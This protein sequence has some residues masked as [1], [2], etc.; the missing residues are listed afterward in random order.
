MFFIYS[1]TLFLLAAGTAWPA[2]PATNALNP[3]LYPDRPRF[4]VFNTNEFRKVVPEGRDIKVLAN[5]INRFTTGLAWNPR[6]KFL[7]ISEV[8]TN[9]LF[10]YVP[11]AGLSIFRHPSNF[12]SGNAY[13]SLG[14]LL[15]CENANGRIVVLQEDGSLEP[16]VSQFEGKSLNSPNDI[17]LKSDGTVWFSDPD[18]GLSQTRT[19]QQGGNFI[20]SYDPQSKICRRR[21]GPFEKPTGLCFSPNEKWLY[22]CNY[23][24]TNLFERID[25]FQMLADG[26]LKAG[27]AFIQVK[28]PS[29]GAVRCDQQGRI[30][31]CAA[32]GVHIYGADGKPIGQISTSLSPA[33]LC[34]GGEGN[35]T[36]FVAARR[37]LYALETLVVGDHAPGAAENSGK[38]VR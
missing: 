6:E 25:R 29:P 32:N 22:L 17:A 33:G 16:L 30:Y 31:T 3:I 38:A 12:A 28:P 23:G 19:G 4:K 20:Y 13:D 36:L 11:G 24:L 14:R 37:Y 35:R 10:K 8:P 18:Y 2:A 7:V 27:E 26:S 15:T 9:T 34:W 5:N 21:A 1:I